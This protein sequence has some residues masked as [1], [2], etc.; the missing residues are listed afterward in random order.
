MSLRGILLRIM[1]WSLGIGAVLGAFAILAGGGTAIW[2]VS[3]TTFT[4]AVAAALMMGASGLSERKSGRTAGVVGML[5]I[6]A[7]FFLLLM[8]IWDVFPAIGGR[9]YAESIALTSLYLFLCGA[10]AV[11]LL[12]VYYEPNTRTTAIAGLILAVAAFVLL[13]V[14]SWWATGWSAREHWFASGGAVGG[15]GVLFAGCLI[16]V[17]V[18]GGSRPALLGRIIGAL[19]ASVALYVGL[20]AIWLNLHEDTGLFRIPLSLAA[21]IAHANLCFAAPLKTGQ[22]WVR[23]AT[24]AAAACTAVFVNVSLSLAHGSD[25]EFAG[26]LAGAAGVMAAC[27]SLALVVLARMNRRMTDHA[28]VLSQIR[29]LTIICPGCQRKQ[30][31]PVG[32]AACPTCR[33]RF[34]LS[35]E[36]P[37]CPQC[38]YLLFMLTSDRCPECGAVLDAKIPG[39][40]PGV[41]DS[42]A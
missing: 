26:R 36:E 38:D 18:P 23:L 40:A 34:N 19:A 33:L 8:L 27:G 25:G 29:E 41:V 4:A 30:T 1:L 16:G 12:R 9:Q 13:M 20:E 37:R 11:G 17:G 3:G 6:V 2:R 21:V 14:G 31:L 7:E 32:E 42:P 22:R 15:I 24:I 5:L 10:P 28:P 35:V 39:V